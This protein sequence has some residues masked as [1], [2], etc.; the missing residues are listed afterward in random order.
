MKGH[1]ISECIIRQIS[2]PQK[3]GENEFHYEVEIYNPKK[4]DWVQKTIF[5]E[6]TKPKLLKRLKEEYML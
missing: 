1:I 4:K 3:S 6:K 2:T 5:S